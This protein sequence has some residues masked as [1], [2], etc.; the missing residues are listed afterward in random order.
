MAENV[1]IKRKVTLKEKQGDTSS[2]PS[3][4][5]WPKIAIPIVLVAVIAVLA[6]VFWP[7]G[8][9]GNEDQIAQKV[10]A[11]VQNPE[12]GNSMVNGAVEATQV[13]S[14]GQTTKQAANEE[15]VPAEEGRETSKADET[16]P[17]KSAFTKPQPATNTT[18]D[19]K[20]V[21]GQLTGDIEQDAKAV[22]RGEFGNGADRKSALGNRYQEIQS[23]VNEIIYN[24]KTN[25]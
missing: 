11:A 12:E 6:I 16:A 21:S 19:A 3:P 15:T 10:P 7:K 20:Q 14:E 23:K 2:A 24:K 22:I 5:K 18:A 17:E 9:K 25:Q 1:H 8:D 13:E 4:N